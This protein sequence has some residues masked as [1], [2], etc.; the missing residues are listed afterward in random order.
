MKKHLSLII[1]IIFI[2]CEK[3]I[4]VDINDSLA[5]IVI[6]ANVSTVL[7][8]SKVSISKSLNLSDPLPYPTISDAIVTITDN[9]NNEIYTLS[10]TEAGLYIH[11][12]LQ[13]IEGHSY[14]LSVTIDSTIYIANSTIPQLV[15][16]EYLEQVGEVTNHGG[17]GPGSGFNDTT[18]AEVIPIYNDPSE[19]TNYYQF[20]V[21][22]NN[23][24]LGDVFVQSDY[25]FNGLEN[26]RSLFIE[27]EIGDQLTIDMQGIDK[28]VYEYLLGL[29]EVINQTSATPTNPISNLSNNAL[30]YFKAHTFSEK[31]ITI[32]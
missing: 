30:G 28:D 7:N 27:S 29:N 21:T 1:I 10:E 14:T 18:I 24:I 12:T 6:E 5:S 22:R 31:L 2:S 20:V 13:G 11:S 17:D 15:E 3:E 9:T 19:Y 32:Q 23:S 16:L 4:E 26:S 25:A 8:N